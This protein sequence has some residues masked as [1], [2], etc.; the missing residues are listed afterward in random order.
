VP[1]IVALGD[2]ITAGTGVNR[3]Q[4]YP[5]L[6][7]RQLQR[8][9][10][11]YKVLNAGVD[12]NTSADAAD[13]RRRAGQ[14]MLANTRILILAIGLNDYQKGRPI[15]EIKENIG[16]IIGLA[17]QR[18][19]KVLLCGFK[20]T[21][22][23]DDRYAGDFDAMYAELAATHNVALVP[24]FLKTVWGGNMTTDGF[25]PSP[26]GHQILANQLIRGLRPMLGAPARRTSSGR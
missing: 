21:L 15:S 1:G 13:A 2:S 16:A 5:A 11:Q 7:E 12:G 22:A 23:I 3:E 18:G 25:H 19:I 4:A 6:L 24:D 10:R 9:G 17:K 14:A 26:F 8:E 20:A